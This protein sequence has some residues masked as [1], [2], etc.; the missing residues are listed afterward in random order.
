MALLQK[1]ETIYLAFNDR[2]GLAHCYRQWGSLECQQKLDGTAK[3]C[4]AVDFH[5]AE[6][7]E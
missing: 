4:S 3:L 7:A 2:A 6:H 1:D 5:R